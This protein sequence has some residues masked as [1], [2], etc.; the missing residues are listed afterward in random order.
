MEIFGETAR[1]QVYA[2]K[3]STAPAGCRRNQRKSPYVTLGS[4]QKTI[5]TSQV[6]IKAGLS[7]VRLPSHRICSLKRPSDS[8]PAPPRFAQKV[9]SEVGG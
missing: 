5:G 2:H 3:L 6:H 8:P 4:H 9:L 1:Q 7:R